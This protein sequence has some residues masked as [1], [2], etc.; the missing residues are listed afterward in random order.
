MLHSFDSTSRLDR[1]RP[2]L[3]VLSLFGCASSQ[4]A[5]HNEGLR[6]ELASSAPRASERARGADLSSAD[7]LD[8][9]RLIRAVLERN[10]SV[11]SARQAWRAALAEHSQRSALDDPR[12]EYSFA[13]LSIISSD[14][15]YGQTITLS[16]KLPW[17]GKLSLAGEVAV[18]EAEAARDD[19]ETTRLELAL[20]ASLL[21]DQYYAVE[22]SLELNAQHHDLVEDIKRAAEAQYETGRVPQQEPLGAEIELAL[23]ERQR[24]GL[25]A[26]RA[27]VVAQI[28]GLLH[29]HPETSV[30]PPPAELDLPELNVASS[31][32]LQ[33]QALAQRPEL[34]ARRS[35]LRARQAARKLADRESYPDIGVMASY[36]SM[37]AMPEHRWML[38]F[39]VN[40]PVQ[41]GRREAA[42]EQS[43]ARIAQV[44]AQLSELGDKIRVE[45]EQARQRVIEA[46][47]VVDLY[48]KRLLPTVRAQIEAA[49]AAYV[50]GNASFQSLIDAER[51]LRNI[52]L[53]YQEALA[54]L[55][56]ERAELLRTLG[57]I[58]GNSEEGAR[59]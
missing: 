47:Q 7:R 14:V 31:Q 53:D 4:V 11:E 3:V 9:A 35:Q 27:V 15:K 25:E 6:A 34:G 36:S 37:W 1:F 51:S 13:P 54:K 43:E 58:P 40:L 50:T 21:F 59:P 24:L 19:Y 17:P 48:K 44:K 23:V 55:G 28:N 45:V 56:Q 42:V 16:Q 57:R 12:L 18:A 26:R 33:Q 30:P 29:R 10:P 38:G 8:R 20:M 39:S 5:K 49:S 46:R 22:R 52:E 32:K 2:C 41:L